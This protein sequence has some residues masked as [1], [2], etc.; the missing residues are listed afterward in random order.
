MRKGTTTIIEFLPSL[1]TSDLKH[2]DTIS[3]QCIYGKDNSLF[4]HKVRYELS[5][6]GLVLDYCINGTP[7]EQFVEIIFQPSNLGIGDVWYFCCP[8]SGRK[9]RKLVLWQGKF[10]HQSSIENHF[11]REQTETSPERTSKKWIRRYKRY[12]DLTKQQMKPYYKPTYAENQTKLA[13]RAT[14]AMYKYAIALRNEEEVYAWF[15]Q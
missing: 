2:W 4:Y 5:R 14:H 11:Y 7:K 13:A 6:E 3:N 15:R 8:V 9:C 10:V 12:Q 1:R